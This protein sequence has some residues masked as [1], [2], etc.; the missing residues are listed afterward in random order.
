MPSRMQGSITLARW[1]M[2]AASSHWPQDRHHP[3]SVRLHSTV[4][5]LVENLVKLQSVELER[6]RLTQAARALPAEFAQAAAA[7]HKAQEEAAAS[8]DAIAREETL[9]TRLERDVTLHR[10]RA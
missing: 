2:L 4:N 9:R 3:P 5:P 1:W 7:L 8:S 6:A 10:Q